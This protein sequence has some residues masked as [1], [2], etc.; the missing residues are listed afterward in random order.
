M[1]DPPSDAPEKL[2]LMRPSPA[3]ATTLP[4]APGTVAE[5]AD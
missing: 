3:V 2:K 1:A 5:D 4:G